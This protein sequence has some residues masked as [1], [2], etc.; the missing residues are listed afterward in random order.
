MKRDAKC[1][2][3]R[4]AVAYSRAVRPR[5]GKHPAPALHRWGVVAVA[6]VLLAATLPVPDG[7]VRWALVGAIIAG[8]F[9]AIEM[10]YR[11]NI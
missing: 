2:S 11:H 6:T 5:R 1:S 10:L 3:R 9:V 8:F 4:A 7:L